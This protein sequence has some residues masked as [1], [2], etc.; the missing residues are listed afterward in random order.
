MNLLWEE[1][2][3]PPV[4]QPTREGFGMRLLSRIFAP[5]DGQVS[6]TYPPSGV[7]CAIALPLSSPDEIPPMQGSGDPTRGRAR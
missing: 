5:G 7:Q 1:L 2:G 3:G 4:T 6:L